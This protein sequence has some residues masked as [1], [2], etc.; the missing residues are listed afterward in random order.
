LTLLLLGAA[1]F[2]GYWFWENQRQARVVAEL[3]ARLDRLKAD[4]LVA[5]V[6]VLS[7]TRA[8]GGS[9]RTRLSFV[10]YKPGGQPLLSKS[11][12]IQGQ[13]LY[14]DALVVRFEDKF[15]E[16]GDGLR[17]K[18]LLL[19]RRAFGNQQ[20][21]D[22]GIPLFTESDGHDPVPEPLRVDSSTPE[23]ERAIWT[24]FWDLANDPD[25]ARR[26][27]VR[28]AQGE[29]PHVLAKPN[30]VYQL[31]LRASGGLEIKPRLPAAI[32][33]EMGRAR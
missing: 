6:A 14:V 10:A 31:T 1:A 30:Q 21:P 16:V 23:F 11:L 20:T 25:A 3:R 33:Q 27:G 28:I 17:G 22:Q 13:E 5:D 8:P 32:T 2:G 12:E 18:S 9:T 24:R 7:Q 15:I 29:A 4:E 26:E 19:F